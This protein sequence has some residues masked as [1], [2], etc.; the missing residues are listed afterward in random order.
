MNLQFPRVCSFQST[1]YTIIVEGAEPKQQTVRGP[2]N[3]TVSS[4]T[5]EV[6]E[7]IEWGKAYPVRVEFILDV[8]AQAL[9]AFKDVHVCKLKIYF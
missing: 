3:G 6:T 7:G 4:D 2:F 8:N 5:V 1:S 9:S